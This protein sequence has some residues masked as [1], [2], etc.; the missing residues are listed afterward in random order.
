MNVLTVTYILLVVDIDGL[1]RLGQ[2]ETLNDVQKRMLL[3]RACVSSSGI[4]QLH[5]IREALSIVFRQPFP[6]HSEHAHKDAFFC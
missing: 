3:I 2:F 5:L 1:Q 6:V 4:D